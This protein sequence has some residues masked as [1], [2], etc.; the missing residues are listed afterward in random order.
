[1]GGLQCRSVIFS[2][3]LLCY[4][5]IKHSCSNYLSFSS[6]LKVSISP[7]KCQ[8]SDDEKTKIREC[9]SQLEFPK[10]DT[11]QRLSLLKLKG[12]LEGERHVAYCMSKLYHLT[13]IPILYSIIQMQGGELDQV[14]LAFK[15]LDEI[16]MS[17]SK[18]HVSFLLNTDRFKALVGKIE[19]S[20][21]EVAML[22]AKVITTLL[23]IEDGIK[24]FF[25]ELH[26]HRTL[27]RSLTDLINT[28]KDLHYDELSHRTDI[29]QYVVALID[30]LSFSTANHRH[31]QEL[32]G[33]GYGLCGHFIQTVLLISN[34]NQKNS[35]AVNTICESLLLGVTALVKEN[36]LNQDDFR[37]Q[38]K[39]G[40]LKELLTTRYQEPLKFSVELVYLLLSYQ[41]DAVKKMITEEIP[42]FSLSQELTDFITVLLEGLE[43]LKRH[44][45]D[46]DVVVRALRVI[47]DNIDSN[48][49]LELTKCYCFRNCYGAWSLL[50][51]CLNNIDERIM[52][53]ACCLTSKLV[54]GNLR[55]QQIL[56]EMDGIGTLSEILS[57]YNLDIQLVGLQILDALKESHSGARQ[58]GDQQSGIIDYLL[59]IIN[60]FPVVFIRAI[61]QPKTGTSPVSP[62]FPSVTTSLNLNPCDLSN[63]AN[64]EKQVTIVQYA[65]SLIGDI[66]IHYPEVKLRVLEAMPGSDHGGLVHLLLSSNGHVSSFYTALREAGS[67]E[68]REGVSGLLRLPRAQTAPGR[69]TK[70]LPSSTGVSNLTEPI[71][72]KKLNS[73]FIKVLLG[74]VEVS[75][76][77]LSNIVKNCPDAQWKFNKHG[78]T[79]VVLNIIHSLITFSEASRGGHEHEAW[80]KVHS[81]S[82]GA[83]LQDMTFTGQGLAVLQSSGDGTGTAT[84]GKSMYL[85]QNSWLVNPE[86][87]AS[88]ILVLVNTCEANSEIQSELCEPRVRLLLHYLLSHPSSVVVNATLLFIS[89]LCFNSSTNQ[90]FFAT[91]YVVQR[92]QSLTAVSYLQLLQGTLV[93]D[94]NLVLPW[95]IDDLHLLSSPGESDP[96]SFFAFQSLAYAFICLANM[97]QIYPAV[98]T[99]ILTAQVHVCGET[100]S[101]M[102]LLTQ[103]PLLPCY[104]I[105]DASITLLS[106]IVNGCTEDQKIELVD[107]SIVDCLVKLVSMDGT[108]ADESTCSE[109]QQKPPSAVDKDR[110]KRE[111]E[112]RWLGNKAFQLLLNMGAPSTTEV[113]RHIHALVELMDNIQDVKYQVSSYSQVFKKGTPEPYLH[114]DEIDIYN[115]LITYLPIFNGL[116]YSSEVCRGSCLESTHT[117]DLLV[118]MSCK[119]G[120]ELDVK[121]MTVYIMANLLT[122]CSGV[123]KEIYAA[124]AVGGGLDVLARLVLEHPFVETE[125]SALNMAADY[126]ASLFQLAS[127]L[128]FRVGSYIVGGVSCRKYFFSPAYKSFLRLAEQQSMQPLSTTGQG[129][130]SFILLLAEDDSVASDHISLP[131]MQDLLRHCAAESGLPVT[132]SMMVCVVV[133]FFFF[134]FFFCCHEIKKTKKNTDTKIPCN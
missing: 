41:N 76:R 87:V 32:Y 85:C 52:Y 79:E 94:E 99:A 95:I 18:K 101:W 48:S 61:Q 59:R 39:L 108:D 12:Y 122:Q 132:M 115:T 100:T 117:W 124:L 133:F 116:V 2:P 15:V 120:I 28:L 92:L 96:A 17:C 33:S 72:L 64:W 3:L 14:R 7:M 63:A 113:L 6:L 27:R 134:F 58:I 81:T 73:F 21:I 26:L 44:H 102:K 29:V 1:M 75:C 80:S 109:Y 10:E 24:D 118:A 70:G 104:P 20:D 35:D 50:F 55:N 13:L 8:L 68:R 129:A 19:S 82:N 106:N 97:L 36:K 25:W 110:L 114:C 4:S 47:E 38:P 16:A 91:P 56:L 54:R 46:V 71:P 22:A 34:E 9:L 78:G 131:H 53:Q 89:H 45:Y 77:A 98:I 5:S 119:S 125:P 40:M 65:I 67:G 57:D 107:L 62:S 86:V 66:V 103:C 42:D 121:T 60:H 126:I 128:I 111:A 74:V 127:Q 84:V 37:T 123:C 88:L 69:L 112:S 51:L 30:M 23:K 83:T 90:R 43:A 31:R 49:N 11:D 130:L 93:P 105:Q